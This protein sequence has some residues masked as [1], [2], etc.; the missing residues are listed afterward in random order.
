M[1]ANLFVPPEW[2]V[3]F[4]GGFWHHIKGERAGQ[5]VAIRREF[6][7]AGH[8]WVIPSLYLCG[9]GVVLDLCMQVD[10][11]HIQAFLDKWDLHPDRGPQRSFTQQERMQ[12]EAENP[13][14]LYLSSTLYINGHPLSDTRTCGTSYN[15][16]LGPAYA[17]RWREATQAMEHYGLDPHFGWAI[18]RAAYPWSTQRKP[19]LRTLS[20]TMSLDPVPIPGPK[21]GIQSPGDTAVFSHRGR[22][23]RLTVVDCQAQTVGWSHTDQPG[24]E[25]PRHYVA[26]RYTL[27]PPL[28]DGSWSVVDCHNGDE[29]RRVSSAPGQPAT[30]DCA[31]G[32]DKPILFE[33]HP[34]EFL[35]C[36]CSSL[37]FHPVDRVEWRMVFRD[38]AFD[39]VT[40]ELPVPDENA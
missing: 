28:P 23:H 9:K 31:M 32:M 34:S 2:K 1:S 27:T 10:P 6:D 33:D 20:L 39:D 16:C 17:T 13:L 25:F 14:C 37:Y 7:W 11:S 3:T 8:H 24:M 18:L 4:G 29:P 26:L 21:L 40:V 38:K 30:T 12:L 15:P 22:E 36:A 35:H 19:K 5:E